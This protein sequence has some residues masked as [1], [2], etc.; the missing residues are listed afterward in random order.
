MKNPNRWMVFLVLIFL[1]TGIIITQAQ[2]HQDVIMEKQEQI[3][4][5]AND[6]QKAEQ[7]YN[8]TKPL[9]VPLNFQ[10]PGESNSSPE[11]LQSEQEKWINYL[12]GLYLEENGFMN[13]PGFTAT[14]DPIADAVSYELALQDL[15]D[16]NPEAYDQFT[17]LQLLKKKKDK[18]LASGYP[19]DEQGRIEVL[20][21]EKKITKLQHELGIGYLAVPGFTAT[22]NIEVDEPAYQQAL[23][24]LKI[25]YPDAYIILISSQQ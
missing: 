11:V 5:R 4:K 9:H 20:I 10:G 14:G 16:I 19:I 25:N 7:D 12:N 24:D 3:Q 2:T 8:G 18:L 17:E 13:I 15:L 1:T 23:I 22:G 6:L 21:I